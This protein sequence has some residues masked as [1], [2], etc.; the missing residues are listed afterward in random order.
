MHDLGYPYPAR[1][2]TCPCAGGDG[3]KA[4][5]LQRMVEAHG[6]GG[7]VELLGAVAAAEVLPVSP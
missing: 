2:V 5:L 1:A 4:P 3:P 6:L 7:R